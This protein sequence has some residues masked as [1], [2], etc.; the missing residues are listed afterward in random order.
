[1]LR[2]QLLNGQAS[3]NRKQKRLMKKG[4]AKRATAFVMAGLLATSGIILPVNSY[5]Y[6]GTDAK[7]LAFEGAE[8]GGRYATGGRNYDVYVVTTLEDYAAGETPIEGS[9]R[10][11][12]EQVAAA[13]GGTIIVFN[14]GGTIELKQTLTFRDRKNITVAGQTAPGDGITLAG[15]DTNISNSENLIIRYLRFRP[16][17]ANVHTGGDSMD[18]LWGRDNKTFIIDHCSFSWNT[19]ETLSTYRGQDGTVQWC[20]VS[21]SLTVSGHSKGRHG[22]GGIFGGD[23][24]V[25]QNNLIANHTSRNPRIGG[26]SMGDPTKDGGSTATVQLSNNVLYNWG[27]NTCYGGGYAYTN[28]IKNF[29]KAGV[30]TRD[31]VAK[32]V[33]DMGEYTK[34]G[35]FYVDGNYL[36]GDDTI[37][38]NNKLG[39][40]MSGATEG[41]NKT[42]VVSTPYTAEGFGSVSVVSA[43]DCYDTV[44]NQAGA[45]YPYR[46]AIDARVVAETKTD[47]GR[48]VNTEDEVGG[49][50]AKDSSRAADFDTD[51]D[52]I[53]DAWETAHGLNPNNDTDSKKI[54]TATGYAY[55]EEY[56]NGL[57]ETVEKA[58]YVSPNPDI[59][60]NL[61][62]NA[63]YNEGENVTV[64][65][66]VKANNGGIIA[67]VEF[68]NG[69]EL[70]GTATTAPYQCT[71]SGLKDGTYNITARA[72][73]NDGNQ[74]QSSVS[75]LHINSTAST[76]EWTST[77]IGNPGVDGSASM[78]DGVLT[79]KGAGKLGTSEGSVKGGEWSDATTDDFQYT[80]K[81]ITGDAEI[82]TK[83]DSA[84]TVD[85]H[86]F[87]GV[88]FRETLDTGSKT[89]ALGMSMVKIS[90]ETTWST[91]LV[92]R[93]T[94]N[95][96][97]SDISE[98]IDSPE[99]AAKA[100][101]PLVRDLHF[102]TGA[103]F[104]GTWFKLV[105][106]GNTF[107]GYASDDGI[108]WTK[109]GSK[110]IEMAEEIY[111][112]F[113]VDANKVANQLNNLSTAKFS[114]I[115]VN[116]EFAEVSYELTNATTTG[117]DYATVGSDFT[118]QLEAEK[119]YKLP[120]NIK[121]TVG[122][123]ELAADAYTYDAETG[124]VTITAAKI[125]DSAAKITITAAAE[126]DIK[127][128]YKLDTY[129][130]T[131]N[132]TV[133]QTDAGLSISQT[134]ESSKMVSKKGDA[135]K[136][137]SYVL[138]PESKEAAKMTLKLTV[139]SFKNGKSSGVYVGAFQTSG[140]Y[141]YD[142]I[143]IRGTG[144]SNAVSPYWI[145]V[146]TK[147]P[148]KDGNAG[149]GGP[150]TALKEGES[151]EITIE[152]RDGIYYATY[153]ADSD[154]AISEKTFKTTEAYLTA[155][156]AAQFGIAINS[157]DVTV[158]D[159][160][161]TDAEG[162]VLYDQNNQF[163]PTVS[164][165]DMIS[166]SGQGSVMNVN[167]TAT[168]GEITQKK[169]ETGKN[170]SY[171]L[172]PENKEIDSMTLTLKVNSFSVANSK[173]AGVFVGAFQTS[174]DMLF[175]SLGFRSVDSSD[176]LS[177]YWIKNTGAAG[178]GSPKYRVALNNRYEVTF[179]K[180]GSSYVA[181][182]ENLDAPLLVD[183]SGNGKY[184]DKKQFKTKEVS[185]NSDMEGIQYGLAI[186]G[187]NVDVLSWVAKD[188]DGN[189]LYDQKDYYKDAGTAPTVTA[190]NKPV[191]SED[192]SSMTVTWTGEGA[193][194][195]GKY[196]V[197]V[198]SDGGATYKEVGRTAETSY[199]YT[200][201][202]TG[203]YTFRV[204]GVCGDQQTNS[205]TSE[206]VN[207]VLPMEA[208][209]IHAES[210]NAANTITWGA[211]KEAKSYIVYRSTNRADG[212]TE[213]GTTTELTFTD[214]K[215]E[216]EVP[217]FYTVAAVGEGNT[218][219]P[220]NPVSIM[221]TA[222]HTGEYAFG[223]EAA[224][225]EVLEKSNDT[226]AD[227][228]AKLKFSYDKDGAV[229]V[230]SNGKEVLSK[231]VKAGE[232]VDA[233][234][235]LANGRNEVTVTFEDTTGVKTYK[236]FNFVKLSHYDIVVDAA[237]A[238]TNEEGA[239]PT[240]KT[241]AE[242]LAAVPADN[243]EQVVIF[244][245]NGTYYEKINITTPN[246]TIIGED[247]EKTVLCFD[248]ASG[249]VNP[250][251]GANYGTSGSASVSIQS[252][253]TN[254]NMEN[255]TVANTFDYPNEDINGKQAV[256]LLTKADQ[257]MF[258]NVRFTGWQ[259]TLQAD[260]NGRQ[261]FKDCYIEGN[262]DW[263]FGSA[264]AVFD[265]CD[266]VANAAGYVTAAS[267][268]TTK[269]TG[270]VFINS[271]ILAKDSSVADNSVALGRPWR[272]NACVTYVNC[273]LDS[274]VRTEGY[275]EMSGN[276]PEN[277]QFYEY[278]SYGPGFAV[279]ENRRQ[280]SK[281]QA[282]Q[283]TVNGVFAREA[284]E[285]LTYKESWDALAAYTQMAKDYVAAGETV[286]VDFTALDEAIKAAEAL[287]AK[288]YK[289][290][291]KVTEA[292]NAAKALDRETASQ[293]TVNALTKNITDAVATL[294]KADV[295]Q[296]PDD[297]EKP[298]T[299]QNPDDNEKPDTPQNPGDNENP[300]DSDKPGDVQNPDD[301]NGS[302]QVVY[303]ALPLTGNG[304]SASIRSD[305]VV[306]GVDSNEDVRVVVDTDLTKEETTSINDT[307]TQNQVALGDEV[308]KVYYDVNLV[309]ASGNVLKLESGRVRLVFGYPAGID[310]TQYDFNV[311]HIKDS[312]AVENLSIEMTAEGIV[313][314]T[315]SL[316]PFVLT[317]TLRTADSDNTADDS[318]TEDVKT[319][320]T[321]NA[322][323]FVFA[324]LL[325]AAFVGHEFFRRKK[326]PTK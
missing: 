97:I 119:G 133:S 312:R 3:P 26:G 235:A 266:I 175:S 87:T 291:T 195:D 8:G 255:L 21:E 292:V 126:E 149:N 66:K 299:P 246:I 84:T 278:H 108:T 277:A 31:Q 214:T 125:T 236:K 80:Y 106:Q 174:G 37:S 179:K 145:K 64:T 298:D 43:Q 187:A 275:V 19:D 110:T 103:Q 238:G 124:S 81:K 42:E 204:T 13:N 130:D 100:N 63:Q 170:V 113:A 273:Y 151:Y 102:K 259:D 18:A 68:Y 2:K 116:E 220:S 310:Y 161:L 48:Y 280:L 287:N 144:D 320:D 285:G 186:V 230:S 216:N 51:M 166:V 215:A 152:K 41:A 72:Y 253:A 243:K 10:Y 16:G 296:N 263:I 112:G 223:E 155:D 318:N 250:S 225:I 245:K 241:V 319:A 201:T 191:I 79:V 91:Y 73:D 171:L 56:F 242:A 190:V 139:N 159:L 60:I 69:I 142:S 61:K 178:N 54:N 154:T 316:S 167:Q 44:L 11:G 101:I 70:V 306:L 293:E 17:A 222:G 109:V 168:E 163:K 12:V 150:K 128:Q 206:A 114:N 295:P 309:D 212:Y 229:K 134:A 301:N 23:N 181:E 24:V 317:Y 27:Y 226:V 82:I 208:P 141:L 96:N 52:G 22:Y 58:G 288:D 156:M 25:F 6:A 30:G 261:Y 198:S 185:L 164:G 158:Q 36:V 254:V 140:D 199:T 193:E 284:G 111:V 93:D 314:E 248:A 9:L 184:S 65:A 32:Q 294:E 162:N 137:V 120:K 132:L 272:P 302:T 286:V 117:A 315:D 257:L 308:H 210:G 182:F 7:I 34:P 169:G 258:N 177:G 281:E 260:G 160:M 138:F 324:E 28:F 123:T 38:A 122:G 252:T 165:S 232:A 240:Y 94:T 290:F 89:A 196:L 95:G 35:G 194:L 90:N 105:R 153:K 59:T 57:V 231:T 325:A 268:E 67:K 304:L 217:Y 307:L 203:S 283:L 99:S 311:Y 313:A 264:Q 75:K 85:N 118:T 233:A 157:T 218:S 289:D 131:E 279:N 323:P 127:I 209:S 322:I 267:T 180:D 270:Y 74:T 239:I 326:K 98:T 76:G 251:T 205:M 305:S 107:T 78:T 148:S 136:N 45:T 104:N 234:I 237:F 77:D 121:V 213:I 219:N 244:V 207:F 256:A 5:A 228:S 265:D 183:A 40:K 221:A 224:A 4:Q 29:L 173:K 14:V 39:S 282:D 192:R 71:Y 274:C 200:P 211:V 197:E 20:I 129:G 115:E 53:P 276:K 143:S 202:A 92:S 269:S 271:R 88:M 249:K 1:M 300:S 33:I 247:S 227:D 49:Y 321:T 46:D 55:V 147:T 47:T 62:D 83:M 135:G 146:D 176:S 50:P 15:W 297:G 86:V 262:V 303:D 172:L 189:V 188:A